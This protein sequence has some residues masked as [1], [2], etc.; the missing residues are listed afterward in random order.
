MF[1]NV[2]IWSVSSIWYAPFTPVPFASRKNAAHRDK[3]REGGRLKAKVEPLLSVET[4]QL[5]SR[6]RKSGPENLIWVGCLTFDERI[7]VNRAVC[8]WLTDAKS[9]VNPPPPLPPPNARVSCAVF[10]LQFLHVPCSEFRCKGSVVRVQ[11]FGFTVQV[12]WF[13][14]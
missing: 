3:R 6:K 2:I 13:R 1:C 9:G 14:A 4:P 10:H 5:S 11:G 8:E 12:V 7:V